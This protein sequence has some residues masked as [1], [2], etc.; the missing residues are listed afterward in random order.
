MF[1]AW[2]QFFNGHAYQLRSDIL[3][4]HAAL[5]TAPFVT[6]NGLAG[7]LASIESEEE[8]AFVESIVVETWIAAN[9]T[10]NLGNY[11]WAAGY[12]KGQELNYTLWDV[13]EPNTG[14]HCVQLRSP[15]LK[16]ATQNCAVALPWLVEFECP[17]GYELGPHGCRSWWIA[18][19]SV[20]HDSLICSEMRPTLRAWSVRGS[21]RV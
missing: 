15:N 14:H 21:K 8:Q 9:D 6:Y 3:D 5:G 1:A 19:S 20:Q 7:H 11:G 10:K 13:S 18:S 17:D 2:Y 4:W 12:D 16:W